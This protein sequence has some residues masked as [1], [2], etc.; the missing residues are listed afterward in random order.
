MGLPFS[1]RK[2]L[3][4]YDI[5][6]KHNYGFMFHEQP[7]GGTA[8]GYSVITQSRVIAHIELTDAILKRI[9]GGRS[10]V[11]TMPDI[12]TFST[13]K[14]TATLLHEC[15][16]TMREKR[17]REHDTTNLATEKRGKVEKEENNDDYYS[18]Q[19]NVHGKRDR[20]ECADNG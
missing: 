16:H 5:F 2:L 6:M 10:S 3:L 15:I 8:S 9:N 20:L 19:P 14:R 17:D 7:L 13:C 12:A 1:F 11:T 18:A 4:E